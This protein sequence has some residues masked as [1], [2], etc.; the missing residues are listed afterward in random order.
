MR[1]TKYQSKVWEKMK[2]NKA[3]IIIAIIQSL[4][5]KKMGPYVKRD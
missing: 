2:Q 4:K 5:K 1:S 3:S